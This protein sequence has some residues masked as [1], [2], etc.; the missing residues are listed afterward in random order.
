MKKIKIAWKILRLASV[1]KIVITY[2]VFIVI[3]SIILQYI[4]PQI[5]N[6]GDGIWYCFVAFTTIG[7]GDIVVT[8]TLG[9]II[10]ILISLFGMII[11]AIM[12]GVLVNYYQEINKIKANNTLEN[13][14]DKLE[15]LPELSKDELREI[16]DK[17]KK[18]RYKFQ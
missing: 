2:L 6:I 4:E 1:D 9:K 7:F 3:F 11:M 15:R 17:I 5:A 12:T 16:S 8:T 14:M 10:T 13:F 18:N